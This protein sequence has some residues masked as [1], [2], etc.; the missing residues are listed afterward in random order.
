MIFL[1]KKNDGQSEP[2]SILKWETD[3][4]F[5]WLKILSLGHHL[6]SKCVS[7]SQRT[8]AITCTQSFFIGFMAL[9]TRLL[10]MRPDHK[11]LHWL[12]IENF[13]FPPSVSFSFSSGEREETTMY[14]IITNT[15]VLDVFFSRSTILRLTHVYTSREKEIGSVRVYVATM[16]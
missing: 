6:L 8:V 11:S 3:N 9:R 10:H 12:S 15:S 1:L 5:L 4:W 2:T 7:R 16:W 13:Q 14:Q